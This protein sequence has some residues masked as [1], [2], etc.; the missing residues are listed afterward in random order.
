MENILE[1]Q[2]VLLWILIILSIPIMCVCM[3]FIFKKMMGD[4]KVNIPQQPPIIPSMK[5]AVEVNDALSFLVDMEFL[6]VVTIPQMTKE[7]PLITDF[8]YYNKEISGNVIKSLS[9]SFYINANMV[10][11]KKA[12]IHETVVRLTMYKILT[13]MNEHNL[14]LKK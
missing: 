13:F 9:T 8:E 12:Y 6:S 4:N 14:S 11:L 1:N 3:L 2:L 7:I 5:T 10:G